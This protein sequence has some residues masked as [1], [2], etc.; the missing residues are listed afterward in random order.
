MDHFPSTQYLVEG[1][2]IILYCISVLTVK[3]VRITLYQ[4]S[5]INVSHNYS[6][7]KIHFFL[8]ISE[9]IDHKKNTYKNK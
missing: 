5:E 1:I 3:S 9:Y 7:V 4:I 8:I 6:L 2:K